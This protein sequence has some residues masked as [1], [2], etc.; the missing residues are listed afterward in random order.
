MKVQ[1]FCVKIIKFYSFQSPLE[2]SKVIAVYAK[3]HFDIRRKRSLKIRAQ[4]I[5]NNNKPAI[6]NSD[7]PIKLS[8][9]STPA[10]FISR[11]Y[12]SV[13]A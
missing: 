2:A 8:L 10:I 6:I 4:N 13:A 11:K 5:E 1:I 12:I 3:K 9:D 7:T